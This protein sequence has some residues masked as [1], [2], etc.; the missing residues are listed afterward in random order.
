MCVFFNII[1][2][3][4]S[5]SFSLFLS[6]SLSYSIKCRF[7]DF[8]SSFWNLKKKEK[9]PCSEIDSD[10]HQS[11]I[12]EMLGFNDFLPLEARDGFEWWIPSNDPARSVGS[13]DRAGRYCQ[14]IGV[15]D[16]YGIDWRVFFLLHS[17][18]QLLGVQVALVVCF[19][20]AGGAE[21]KVKICQG[22]QIRAALVS[23]CDFKRRDVHFT[24]SNDLVDRCK[25]NPHPFPPPYP[26]I[27]SNR[28]RF[29]F[30][31]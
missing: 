2:L 1:S 8:C 12:S 16:R 23:V 9:T 26:A 22:S 17:T 31:Y 24:N 20:L 4:L 11:I 28:S 25:L 21:A 19:V 18:R 7:D 3:S 10:Y 6:L 5:L 27:P 13:T 14:S 30:N 29:H 15:F